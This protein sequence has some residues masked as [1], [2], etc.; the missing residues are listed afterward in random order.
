MG[1][2]Y[3]DLG[4]KDGYLYEVIATTISFNKT[5]PNASCL[6]IRVKKDLIL[7]KPY[8]DTKTYKN[9]TKNSLICINFVDNIY[10]YALAALK[11]PY[12]SKKYERYPLKFYD[13]YHIKEKNKDFKSVKTNIIPYIRDAWAIVICKAKKALEF[14]KEDIFGTVKLSEFELGTISIVKLKE[15]HKLFNRAENLTLEA[16]ILA[17]RLKIAVLKNDSDIIRSYRNK[18]N[19]IINNIDKFSKNLEV[20]KSVNL[21]NEYIRNLELEI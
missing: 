2:L 1:I 21:I 7:I 4:L 9:L 16:L 15:S 6:G 11:G 17:T 8:H 20:T 19:Y 10:L 13:Y 12:L 5:I 14:D 3:Q 18:I